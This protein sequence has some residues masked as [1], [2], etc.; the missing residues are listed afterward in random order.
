LGNPFAKL[1]LSMLTLYVNGDGVC[2]VG[3]EQLAEDSELSAATVRSRLKWLEDVGAIARF[4][5]WLDHNG[6]RNSDARGKRT[7]DE[8]RL[9]IGSDPDDIERRA[10]GGGDDDGGEVSP[11]PQEG[12]NPAQ[13]YA[14]TPPAL[15]QT[16]DSAQGL[17]S[18][19]EPEPLP[20]APSGGARVVDERFEEFASVYPNPI[21]DM[22]KA[23][24]VWAAYTELERKQAIIGAKGYA[25]FIDSE[26]R[27]GRKRAV[28]DAHRWLRD[29][30][31]EGYLS[32]GHNAQALAQR[33]N[34]VEG[35]AQWMAWMVF[36]Y[37]CGELEGVPSYLRSEKGGT[38][39]G[40]V[41]REW[42]PVGRGLDLNPRHWLTW[43]EGSPQFAAWRDRLQELPEAKLRLRG[44]IIDGKSVRVLKVPREWP[45]SKAATG[46]PASA[47]DDDD[48]IKTQGGLG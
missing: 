40:S 22:G 10:K 14:G 2:F 5:Q 44:E 29:R 38:R 46:P 24:C 17:T 16:S 42:P 47:K 30:L 9:L 6:K 31:Y 11:A 43:R 23:R 48:F 25:S 34:A 15:R 37:C 4:P 8:I 20:P 19:P 39:Y 21:T 36:Y 41:P 35:S 45:P 18:E 27:A 13:P 26:R 7:T 28:K 33:F 32:A 1:V 3:I 12:L